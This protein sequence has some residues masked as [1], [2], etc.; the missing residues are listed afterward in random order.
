MTQATKILLEE[1]VKML[2]ACPAGTEPAHVDECTVV[3]KEPPH[4]QPR[5]QTG[6]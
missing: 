5:N 1:V 4:K 3:A 2:E 6:I